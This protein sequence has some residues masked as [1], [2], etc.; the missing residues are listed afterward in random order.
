MCNVCVLSCVFCVNVRTIYIQIHF[1]NGL[2][3]RTQA[4]KSVFSAV[5]LKQFFIAGCVCAVEKREG[6]K[7]GDYRGH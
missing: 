4:N 2:N 3:E 5:E 7:K 1:M 6:Q